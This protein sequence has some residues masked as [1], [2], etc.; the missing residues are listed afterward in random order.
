[1]GTLHQQLQATF[2][3]IGDRTDP[4][5]RADPTGWWRD[6]EIL[7]ELGP[8]LASLFWDENPTVVVATQSRGTLL[9]T[10]V[11]VCLG[12]GMT[13]VRKGANRAADSDAWWEATTAPDYRDSQLRLGAR[14]SLLKSGDRAL[15]VDDWIATGAQAQATQEIVERSGATWVGAAVV[16][17]GLERSHLRRALNLRAVLNIRD[18]M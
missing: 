13:E 1:M 10:L 5:Y 12:I 17:D 15:F 2:R 6:P 3:W 14:K 4:D 11:A 18:L 8:A 7:A 16:V 9:G